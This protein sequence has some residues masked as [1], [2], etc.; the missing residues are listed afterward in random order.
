[1]LAG[2]QR[3]I[4][5]LDTMLSAL[6]PA[7]LHATDAVKLLDEFTALERRAV[8]GKTLV[9]DRA[10][11][12]AEWTRR[13]YRSPEAWLAAKAGTTVGEAMGTLEASHKLAELPETT[14]AVRKG[15][16]SGPQLKAIASAATPENERRPAGR[17]E[18]RQRQTAQGAL[19]QGEG[20]DAFGRGRVPAAERIQQGAVLPPWTD[21]AGA[22]RFEGTATAALG[23][24]IDAAL[25]PRPSVCSRPPTPRDTPRVEP[26]Y[27]LDAL[28]NLLTGG[29][30]NLDATV[31]IR[32]TRPGCRRRG[33]L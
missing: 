17:G 29:G 23:A 1:M 30:A 28:V 3:M 25:A 2:L 5:E 24:R 26:G 4:G 6:D 12:A 20:G 15:S 19:R 33:H 14:S 22:Y 21:G 7:A 16:L 31:V 10:A 18:D 8:A 32:S 11:D 13:G 9:A 27:R